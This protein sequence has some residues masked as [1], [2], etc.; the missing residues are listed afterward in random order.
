[1]NEAADRRIPGE[2]E[3]DFGSQLES[4]RLRMESALAA[5]LPEPDRVP[6][7]LHEAMRYS[8]LGGGK[9]IRPALVFAT[10][11]AVGLAEDD[12][13]AAACAIELVHVYSLVHD[14]LPAMDNDDMRRGRPTCHKAYDEAT[15]LLVGDALQPLAFQL[16]ACDPT[17]RASPA[18][19]LRLID[20][21]AHAIGTL[22]MAGGQAI[23][24]AS[25][26]MRLD[27]GQVDDMH[28]RKTGAVIRASVL[29]AA[30][31]AP[32]LSPDLTAALSRFANAVGLAFQI[33]DDVLD[34]TGD[35][36]LLGKATGADS[37]RGKPTYP[38]IIGIS[39]S[40]Q[41]VRHLHNQAIQA[42]APLG[43]AAATLRS[44]A[45]WLLSRQY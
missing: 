40:Q 32:A 10:A 33:Q 18:V 3:D 19:R 20:M 43:D 36:S 7:R 4:W 26:G 11:R 30:E 24:L 39:A 27:I 15:A 14:D 44:L 29:M 23:D 17:L 12:V 41:R 38:S 9:R 42:L 34:V 37:D 13:E 31:C 6:A 28:A 1:V 45:H 21:L 16:L 22:G 5:R 2:D 25:Q 35:A 8:V